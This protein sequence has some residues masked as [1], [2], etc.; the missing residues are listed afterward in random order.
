MKKNVWKKKITKNFTVVKA[1]LQYNEFFLLF[2]GFQIFYSHVLS[3]KKKSQNVVHW[4]GNII[5]IF[6]PEY[7]IYARQ[8]IS[9]AKY[10]ILNIF[11]LCLRT[12]YKMPRDIWVV[13][14]IN[15]MTWVKP[16]I[17]MLFRV[18]SILQFIYLE[19][20]YIALVYSSINKGNSI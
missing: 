5:H 1:E 2:Y 13:P 20:R 10:K 17:N 16:K 3:Q 18:L 14:W 6:V 19:Y 8:M 7:N 15:A 9:F 11:Y 12:V 4:P